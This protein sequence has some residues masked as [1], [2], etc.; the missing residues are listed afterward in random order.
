MCSGITKPMVRTWIVLWKKVGGWAHGTQVHVLE[1][2]FVEID[3]IELVG[4]MMWTDFELFGP[5]RVAICM[6]APR[7]GMN[8]FRRIRKDNY[9]RR[10]L[11]EDAL[12]Q[13]EA[14]IAF[15]RWRAS[16]APNRCR[17]IVTHHRP[18]RTA[19]SD[20]PIDAAYSS[21]LDGLI[22]DL[23]A[24]VSFSGHVHESD[25]RMVGPT[26]LVSNPKGYGPFAGRDY[27][28]RYNRNFDP[29]LTIDVS[30]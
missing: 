24:R 19:A 21:S 30:A 16:R 27:G 14:A 10:F 23:G 29:L 6:E 28:L 3:G 2:D 4:A 1:N 15:L 20:D 17:V 26:R 8:D 5:D 12:A 11:P 18:V 22:L 25:D 9:A 7:N 13:H